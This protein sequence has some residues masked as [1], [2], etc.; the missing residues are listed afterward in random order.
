M[1]LIDGHHD[2]HEPNWD[3]K[4]PSVWEESDAFKWVIRGLLAAIGFLGLV[5]L[6]SLSTLAHA[7][8]FGFTTGEAMQHNVSVCLDL[9]SAQIVAEADHAG[10]LEAGQRAWSTLDSCAA[11][12]VVGPR[13]GQVVLERS[14][15]RAGERLV[16]KVVEILHPAGPDVIGYFLTTRQ[17]RRSGK[18]A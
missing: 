11:V 13:V 14:V 16:L 10:G 12:D 3:P 6:W 7:E 5:L 15:Q 1:K 17:V 9:K 8:D 2:A 18:D 4:F